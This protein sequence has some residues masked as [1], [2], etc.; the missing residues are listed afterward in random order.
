MLLDDQALMVL[1]E[2]AY[3][4]E[5]P[6]REPFLRSVAYE[7]AQYKPEQIG[8][9]LVMRVARPLQREFLVWRRT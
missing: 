4:L 5:E 3:P 6:L 1:K 8:P 2:L 9:G 7:L